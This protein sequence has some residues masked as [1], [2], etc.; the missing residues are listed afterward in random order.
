MNKL[1]RVIINEYLRTK[2]LNECE[3]N[4]NEFETLENKCDNDLLNL[5]NEDIEK[6]FNEN[7]SHYEQLKN[8]INNV[9]KKYNYSFIDHRCYGYLIDALYEIIF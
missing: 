7:C 6:Y 4:N 8:Y 2:Y 9:L 5:F 3:F 1:E